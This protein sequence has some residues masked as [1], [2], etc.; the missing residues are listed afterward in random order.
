MNEAKKPFELPKKPLEVSSFR[1]KCELDDS[2]APVHV[3]IELEV[4]L[5]DGRTLLAYEGEID[6]GGPDINVLVPAHV[7]REFPIKSYAPPK[8]ATRRLP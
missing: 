2:E 5:S 7:I 3:D 6:G 1:I 4:T 8:T